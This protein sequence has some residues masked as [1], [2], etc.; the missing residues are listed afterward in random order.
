MPGWMTR[1]SRIAAYPRVDS[2]RQTAISTM[3]SG[4]VP[5]RSRWYTPLYIG[6]GVVVAGYILIR[7]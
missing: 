1:S 6:Y 3:D 7:F 5:S 4:W 2:T